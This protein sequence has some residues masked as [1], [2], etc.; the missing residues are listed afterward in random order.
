MSIV[1][2][3]KSYLEASENYQQVCTAVEAMKNHADK[4]VKS[5]KAA[6]TAAIGKRDVVVPIGDGK[7]I[8]ATRLNYSYL[9][10]EFDVYDCVT[11]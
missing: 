11:E 4:Q 7:A 3:A 1:Q 5:A 2:L 9:A 6:L 8:R 10:H